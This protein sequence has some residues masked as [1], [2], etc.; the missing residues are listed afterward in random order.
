MHVGGA[1]KCM[2]E[3]TSVVIIGRVCEALVWEIYEV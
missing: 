2:P 3:G 1:L